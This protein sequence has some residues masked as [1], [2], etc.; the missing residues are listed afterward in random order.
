MSHFTLIAKDLDVAPLLAEL[1]AHPDLWDARPER[2]A[3]NSPHRETSDIWCRY[4]SDEAMREPDFMHKPHQSILYPRW[5]SSHGLARIIAQ[6]LYDGFPGVEMETGGILITR[7]PPGKQVYEHHDRGSWHAEHYTTKVWVVLR[8]NDR[9]VNTVEDE[10][11]VWRPG[12][13]YSHDNLRLH[14]VRNEGETERLCLILC[15]RRG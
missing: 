1:D 15:F 12:C 7:I 2:R 6:V 13:A 4:A 14:S 3:G 11:M 5:R 10:A 8:G 9:C